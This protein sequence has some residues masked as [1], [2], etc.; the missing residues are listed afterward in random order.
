MPERPTPEEVLANEHVRRAYLGEDDAPPPRKVVAAAP[1]RTTVVAAAAAVP[2]KRAAVA[3]A[4]D[5]TV[6][7][8]GAERDALFIIVKNVGTASSPP[9][10]LQVDLAHSADE[11]FLAG[12][13][14][15]VPALAVNQSVRIRLR[16]APVINVRVLALVDPKQEVAELNE[17]NNDLAVTFAAPTPAAEPSVLEAEEVWSGGASG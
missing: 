11:T 12:Q 7:E 13:T 3:A 2:A 17:L 8:I 6:S 15:R 4:P 10:R 16:S 5:L 14:L 9:T 1:R